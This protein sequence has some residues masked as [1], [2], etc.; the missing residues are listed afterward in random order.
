MNYRAAGDKGTIGSGFGVFSTMK[1]GLEKGIANLA[2]YAERFRD[3]GVTSVD[4]E[5]VDQIGPIYCEGNLWAGKV[6][7]L[8]N[9]IMAMV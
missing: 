1:A 8:Y 5:H 4:I 9:E 3:R 2:S 7:K 6:K